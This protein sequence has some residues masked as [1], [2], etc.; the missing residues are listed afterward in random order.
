M[1][2]G[3]IGGN[4]P[5]RPHIT[6]ANGIAAELRRRI[7]DGRHAPGDRLPPER[8]LAESFSASRGTIREAL[9][10]LEERGLVERRVGSGTFVTYTP[11]STTDDVAEI[12]SP[13]ELV[14]VRAAVERQMARLA[15][16]NATARD[17]SSLRE[18]A[19]NMDAL[20]QDPGR[21]S[22]WDEQFHLRLAEATH[23]P[24]L[25]DIYQRINHVRGHDQWNTIKDKVLTPERIAAYNLEH[26]KLVSAIEHR[27]A[28]QAEKIVARHMS[29]AHQDLVMGNAG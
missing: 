23:N 19:A 8:V 4:Q 15:V 20:S 26:R 18:A 17:I 6:A 2:N 1:V 13:L 12:T 24:L 7:Q 16:R 25:V 29:R 28:E 27:D 21:F 9:R 10:S 11:E 14:E 22:V 5:S 3:Q